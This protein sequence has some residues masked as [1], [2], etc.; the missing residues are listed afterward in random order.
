MNF[1]TSFS[2]DFR[3]ALVSPVANLYG[4]CPS[5]GL[6]SGSVRDMKADASVVLWIAK[7]HKPASNVNI[8][9]EKPNY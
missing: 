4:P 2:F 3:A 6:G 8:T 5:G 1:A 7:Y 9:P